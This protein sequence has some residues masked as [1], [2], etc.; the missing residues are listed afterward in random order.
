MIIFKKYYFDAAHYMPDS[1]KITNI[2]KFMG[3]VMKLL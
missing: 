1:K 2:I 3:I